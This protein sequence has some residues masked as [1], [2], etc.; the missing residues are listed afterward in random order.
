MFP[1]VKD[2]PDGVQYLFLQMFEIYKMNMWMPFCK[3]KKKKFF[4][5][6]YLIYLESIHKAIPMKS[7]LPA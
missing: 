1:D 3:G 2:F 7:I 5:K 4:F 6:Y